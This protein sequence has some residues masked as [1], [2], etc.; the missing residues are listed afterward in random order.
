[1]TVK[2]IAIEGELKTGSVL[3]ALY[4]LSGNE[5]ADASVLEWYRITPSGEE[6]LVKAV[7]S[8][9]DKSYTITQE[10]AGCLIKLVIKPETISGTTGDSKSFVSAQVPKQ[11]NETGAAVKNL[12]SRI[13]HHSMRQRYGP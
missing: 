1:M 9:A 4:T 8:Y 7:P 3:K 5:K 2:D 6:T 11:P 12:N 13:L 10:D